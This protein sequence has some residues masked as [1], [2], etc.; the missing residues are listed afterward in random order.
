MQMSYL[1]SAV[2]AFL[3]SSFA[4][5]AAD[6]GAPLYASATPAACRAAQRSAFRPEAELRAVVEDVLRYRVTRVRTDAG[7]YAVQASDRRGIPYEVRFLGDDLK[8]V[9]RHVIKEAQ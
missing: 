3:V 7:C 1:A 6:S 4:A 2:A 5:Q 9:S 8:M